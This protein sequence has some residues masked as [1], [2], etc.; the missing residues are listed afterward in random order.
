[1]AS[2]ESQRI[3][4]TFIPSQSPVDTPIEQQRQEWEDSVE[5]ANL[6]LPAVVT[7][8]D[9][10][11]LYGEWIRASGSDEANVILFLH[12]GGYNAGSCKT[13][14]ALAAHVARAAG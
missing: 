6:R 14:R 2:P 8:L 9:L 13:H 7:P 10:D 4:A 3:R 5:L 12:G 11:G 1:M